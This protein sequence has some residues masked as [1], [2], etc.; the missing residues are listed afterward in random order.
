M[1]TL[2]AISP[3]AGRRKARGRRSDIFAFGGVAY[4]M[5]AACAR[6]AASQAA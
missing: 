6:F 2:P 4:E 3:E 5:I 1:G